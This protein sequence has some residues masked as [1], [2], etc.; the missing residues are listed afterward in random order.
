MDH[1]LGIAAAIANGQNITKTW[2]ETAISQEIAGLSD[3]DIRQIIN[4]LFPSGVPVSVTFYESLASLQHYIGFGAHSQSLLARAW[5]VAYNQ[6]SRDARIEMLLFYPAGAYR[7][8]WLG[9]R[10]VPEFLSDV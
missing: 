9:T 1:L 10:S 6:I 2:G 8:F 7:V 3:E 5:R 4:T